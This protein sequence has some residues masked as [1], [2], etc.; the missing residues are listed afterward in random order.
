[1]STASTSQEQTVAAGDEL[2]VSPIRMGF[3]IRKL[4]L[5]QVLADKAAAHPDKVFLRMADD[6]REYSYA[7]MHRR[8]NRL[9]HGLA[10]QGIRQGEIVAPFLENCAEFLMLLFAI[11]K[12]GS[13]AAPVNTAARG[14][15]LVYYLELADAV[16]VVTS[17][18]LLPRLL[19]VRDQLPRLRRVFVLDHA[20]RQPELPNGT[21][22]FRVLDVADD[23]M[24]A[25]EVRYNDL[26]H[27]AFTSGTTGPSKAAAYVHAAVLQGAI[28]YTE[29][30]G[31]TADDTYYVCLPFF[32]TNALRS[33][34]WIALVVGGTVALP[35]RFS[36]SNFWREV[37]E[38][39]ATTFNL[40]GSMLNILWAQPPSPDDGRHHARMCRSAP[41]PPFCREFEKRFN[42][43]LITTYGMSDFGTPVAYTLDE[44]EAKLGSA[45]KLQNGWKVRIVDDD[46]FDLPPGT[47]GEI[48]LRNSFMW[49]EASGYHKMPEAT[50]AAMRNGWFHT[51]DLGYLD[52]D[53]YLYFVGRKKDAI[54]RRGE[55]I[56]AWEVEQVL[57]KH[58]AIAES[59]VYAVPSEMSEDEVAVTIALR[60]GQSLAPVEVIEWCATRMAY[61]MV[62]RYVE[63]MTDLPRTLSQKIEKFRLREM[64]R[65]DMGK[66]WDRDQAG[67]RL[68]R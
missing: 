11:A 15:L 66:F 50:V 2:R 58:P 36:A 38:T 67:I 18:A 57:H 24:P 34:T 14:D 56:S 68:E 46:D 17:P 1:M 22:D 59:A 26:T 4:T 8:S 32:H 16:A 23:S 30:W 48:V 19:E 47:P 53:G 35:R 12:N 42:I 28:A 31:Y 33:S 54:R 64:A 5:G 55:N 6:G 52:A 7:D 51:G 65:A 20:D 29:A 60:P 62:P 44:P 13:A 61:Y 27:L 10:A 39:R 37:R 25:V 43:R 40:L 3:D 49:G 45:G 41:M 9:A 63:F 21:L